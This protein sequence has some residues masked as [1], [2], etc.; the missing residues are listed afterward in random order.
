[1]TAKTYVK[2]RAHQGQD[3]SGD[4]IFALSTSCIGSPLVRAELD[5]DPVHLIL[6]RSIDE[7]LES[8][9]NFT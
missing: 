2:I 5:F 1:M 4:L 6:D 9:M 8:E 7:F 3:H